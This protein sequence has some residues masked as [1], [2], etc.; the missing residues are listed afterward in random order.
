MFVP[1]VLEYYLVVRTIMFGKGVVLLRAGTTSSTRPTSSRTKSLVLQVGANTARAIA[2]AT[3]TSTRRTRTST[4]RCLTTTTSIYSHDAPSPAVVEE[5]KW[6]F[7]MQ[8]AHQNGPWQAMTKA[9]QAHYNNDAITITRTST[10]T[11]VSEFRVLDLACG[12]RG[13]PATRIARALPVRT[14]LVPVDSDSLRRT[15]TFM[16]TLSCLAFLDFLL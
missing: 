2:R 10:S 6:L 8:H 4:T 14:L 13:E 15:L 3:A 16:H 9:V 7:S 11:A 5:A 1:E 12:P